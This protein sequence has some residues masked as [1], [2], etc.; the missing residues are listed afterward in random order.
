MNRNISRVKL[1]FDKMPAYLNILDYIIL[2]GIIS[3]ICSCLI[4]NKGLYWRIDLDS[5][6]MNE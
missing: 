3:F 6:V 4:I 2:D 1:L 5:N